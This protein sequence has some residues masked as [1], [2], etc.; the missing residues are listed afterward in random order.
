MI[1]KA[2]KAVFISQIGKTL[3]SGEKHDGRAPDYDD[4]TLNGDILVYNTQLDEALEIRKYFKGSKEYYFGLL[5]S[6]YGREIKTQ[7]EIDIIKIITD[8]NLT[9]FKETYRSTKIHPYTKISF[10]HSA[11]TSAVSSPTK[12]WFYRSRNAY[13]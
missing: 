2:K 4:W 1:A 9:I 8:K 10:V 13:S 6:K 11:C 12:Q 3:A 5:N 7:E